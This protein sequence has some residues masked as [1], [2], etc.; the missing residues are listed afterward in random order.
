MI[1]KT[2]KR[3]LFTILE[4]LIASSMSA[5]FGYI[6]ISSIVNITNLSTNLYKE[7]ST[8]QSARLVLDLASRSIR[9]A[10]PL[11]GCND[12]PA[13]TSLGACKTLDTLSPNGAPAFIKATSTE[14]IF[15][16]YGTRSAGTSGDVP[17]LVQVTVNPITTNSPPANYNVNDNYQICVTVYKSAS[18]NPFTAWRNGSNVPL[19]LSDVNTISYPTTRPIG[20]DPTGI[21]RRCAGPIGHDTTGLIKTLRYRTSSNCYYDTSIGSCLNI[22]DIKQVEVNF[23]LSY[24]TSNKSRLLRPIQA[25]ININSANLGG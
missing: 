10:V 6:V 8:Q 7:S 16:S 15:Y 21:S 9:N 14:A 5:V 2:Y 1:R 20:A 18:S 12:T 13:V 19:T 22:G 17:D 4:V 11:Y 23:L 3:K 25:F 24:T